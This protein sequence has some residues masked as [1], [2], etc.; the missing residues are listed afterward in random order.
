MTGGRTWGSLHAGWVS[1]TT[2]PDLLEMPEASHIISSYLNSHLLHPRLPDSKVYSVPGIGIEFCDFVTSCESTNG[3]KYPAS[4][5]WIHLDPLHSPCSADSGSGVWPE[6]I[7]V[8]S[9]ATRL[10][11]SPDRNLLNIVGN[12]PHSFGT[13]SSQSVLAHLSRIRRASTNTICMSDLA[14]RATLAA[15]PR[16]EDYI[17]MKKLIADENLHR[18]IPRLNCLTLQKSVAHRKLVWGGRG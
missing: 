18:L 4:Y 1:S 9:R 5:R 12:I 17:Q 15:K 11:P 13:P 14:P 3:T 6:A 10:A 7:L 8:L 2:W 16:G